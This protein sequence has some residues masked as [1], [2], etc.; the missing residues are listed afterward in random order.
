M[1]Q[2]TFVEFFAGGG[3]ARAGLGDKWRCLFANDFDQKKVSTYEANWGA[4][5]IKQADVATST[6]RLGFERGTKMTSSYPPTT[7]APCG[8]LRPN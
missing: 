4:G 3:M 8:A 1:T 5:D 6:R 7:F 2:F